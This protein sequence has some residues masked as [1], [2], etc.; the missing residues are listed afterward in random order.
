MSLKVTV[1]GT[2][3]PQLDVT[4]AVTTRCVV[5]KVVQVVTVTNGEGVP[6]TI[7]AT[8]PFGTKAF[9]QV[10]AGKSTSASF[11]TRLGAIEPGTVGLTATATVGGETVTVETDVAYAGA[12]CG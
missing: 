10:A 3:Q 9:G 8:T 4:A 5:G 6:V 12:S 2:A 11:T 7:T 1:T